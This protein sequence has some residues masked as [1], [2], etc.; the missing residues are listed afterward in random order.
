MPRRALITI[1]LLVLA[2][3]W[4]V[5]GGVPLGSTDKGTPVANAFHTR[6]WTPPAATPPQSEQVAQAEPEPPKA[7]PAPPKPKPQPKPRPQA[8]AEP[9]P[10]AAPAEPESEPEPQQSPSTDADGAMA[11][12][13]TAHHG[14]E[15]EDSISPGPQP[16]SSVS[17]PVLPAPPLEPTLPAPLPPAS[18]ASAA[19]AAASSPS[20]PDDDLSAGVDIR[21]PGAAAGAKASTEPPPIKLPDSVTLKYAVRGEI[22]KLAYNVNGQMAWTNNGTHYEARQEVSA[23]LLGTRG[24]ISTGNITPNGLAPTRFGDKGKREL[25]AHFDFDKRSVTFSANTPSIA[26]GAGAQDRVSVMIQLGAMIAAAPDRYPPGTKIS[27][28]T[29]GP[30][31]ADRWI[32]TVGEKEVLDLPAGP[33]PA[34]R[35]QKLPRHERDVQ[36]DLWLGTEKQYLPV[37]LRLTQTNGDFA[38]LML[39]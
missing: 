21:P 37:R 7:E 23:F 34:L 30:R 32:F 14:Q 13:A 33:T 10:P 6:M 2:L 25:A 29:I 17:E 20:T 15:N 5:L 4:L 1:T 24:Q 12:Q 22:K 8:A 39:K 28:T 26:I 19:L 36:A 16:G 11:E 9:E 27:F 38:E 3:H 31:N 18:A 35:L